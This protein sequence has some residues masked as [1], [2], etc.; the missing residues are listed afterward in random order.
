M[1]INHNFDI[2]IDIDFDININNLKLIHSF[3]HSFI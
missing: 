1:L 3:I 2:D